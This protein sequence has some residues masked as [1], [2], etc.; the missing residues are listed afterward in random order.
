MAVPTLWI[1]KYFDVIKDV[2][3]SYLWGWI[4]LSLD[5]FALE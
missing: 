2:L 4:D 5:A 3:A 1:V